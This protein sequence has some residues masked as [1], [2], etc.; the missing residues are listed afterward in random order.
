M[1][2]LGFCQALGGSRPGQIFCSATKAGQRALGQPER[3][4]LTFNGPEQELLGPGSGLVHAPEPT[5]VR[6]N[7]KTSESLTMR[8][9]STSL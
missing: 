3:G 4:K 8:M 7:S 5:E 1:W 9:G 6:T 2:T